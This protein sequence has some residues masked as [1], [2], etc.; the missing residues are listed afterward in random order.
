[1]NL[2][3]P[4]WGHRSAPRAQNSIKTNGFLTFSKSL[5]GPPRRLRAAQRRPLGPL[6]VF[7]RAPRGALGD[8]KI[9]DRDPWA[10]RWGPGGGEQGLWSNKMLTYSGQGFQNEKTLPVAATDT[11]F[12]KCCC[13]CREKQSFFLRKVYPLDQTPPKESP[14]VPPRT[15]RRG[16]KSLPMIPRAAPTTIIA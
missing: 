3:W 15:Q 2:F 9:S 5:R 7:V 11:F 6:L 10:P 12:R 13:G 16:P 1:M 4:P 14:K 8:L